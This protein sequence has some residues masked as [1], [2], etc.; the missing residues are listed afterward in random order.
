MVS[1]W[2]F[3]KFDKSILTYI[4]VAQKLGDKYKSGIRTHKVGKNQQIQ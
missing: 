4:I 2:E 3:D 1:I